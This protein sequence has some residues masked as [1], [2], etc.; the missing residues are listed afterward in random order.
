MPPGTSSWP[1]LSQPLSTI[2]RT[3]FLKLSGERDGVGLGIEHRRV[4]VA[5][6]ERLGD[7][8]LRQAGHL[9]GAFRGPRVDVQVGELALA[10][11]L[12]DAQYL[13]QVEFL[14]TH[15]GLVVAHGLPP[16]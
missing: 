9:A 1:T 11:R 7:G 3:D 8:A 2:A 10:E 12:V 4:A 13:E 15:V 14:V 6:A 5:V 16:R